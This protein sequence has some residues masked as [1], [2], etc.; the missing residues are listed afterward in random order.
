MLCNILDKPNDIPFNA[1]DTKSLAAPITLSTPAAILPPP[2]IKL[3]LRPACAIDLAPVSELIG[4][5]L[6]E[7]L[8][9]TLPV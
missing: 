6:L 5:V 3:K 8:S 7:K 4:P 9:E 2:N 1:P